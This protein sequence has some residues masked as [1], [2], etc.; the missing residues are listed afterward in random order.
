MLFDSI[1]VAVGPFEQASSRLCTSPNW[2]ANTVLELFTK[3]SLSLTAIEHANHNPR[4]KHSSH[5]IWMPLCLTCSTHDPPG[6]GISVQSHWSTCSGS[7]MG[8]GSVGSFSVGSGSL[9]EQRPH[10]V[11]QY[12]CGRCSV[13]VDIQS[14]SHFPHL[15]CKH[16]SRPSQ[17][18]DLWPCYVVPC[19]SQPQKFSCTIIQVVAYYHYSQASYLV[20]CSA[21]DPPGGEISVQSHLIA[22]AGSWQKHRPHVVWQYPCGRFSF[23]S[24]IQSAW[25]F[26][27]LNCKHSLELL[28]NPVA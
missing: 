2:T 18:S 9:Q 10:V 7:S 20:T 5:N 28:I 6:G 26:P 25:H 1:H 23:W 3:H 12:P 19:P 22:F 11:W 4:R 8:S 15:S 21:H 16:N 14:T 27:H 24:T 17:S 13:W